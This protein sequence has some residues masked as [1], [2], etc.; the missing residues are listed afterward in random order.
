MILETGTGR[1]VRISGSDGAL[2]K[3]I[4]LYSSDIRLGDSTHKANTA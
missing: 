3:N 2:N 1:A 4:F